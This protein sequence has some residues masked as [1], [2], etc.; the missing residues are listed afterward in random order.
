M[1]AD[2]TPD[3]GQPPDL[4]HILRADL[5]A[6]RAGREQRADHDVLDLP[7]GWDLIEDDDGAPYPHE[8]QVAAWGRCVERDREQRATAWEEG[9]EAAED[10]EARTYGPPGPNGPSDPTVNP[11]WETTP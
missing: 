6:K 5:E 10:D 3:K 11:Y 9:Y 2:L 8:F 4:A 1:N 7:P